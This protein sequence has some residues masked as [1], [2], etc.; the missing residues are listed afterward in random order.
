[1]RWVEHV[2]RMV[3]EERCV[4]VVVGILKTR[5]YLEGIGVRRRIILKMIAKKVGV[6]GRT[7]LI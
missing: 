1:M 6:K 4:S 5:D 3:E 2:A 7:A